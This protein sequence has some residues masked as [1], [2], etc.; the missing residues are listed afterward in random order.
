MREA[1]RGLSPTQRAGLDADLL[2]LGD[3]DSGT[4]AVWKAAK[5]ATPKIIAALSPLVRDEP[6]AAF[7]I[8]P[9]AKRGRK[10]EAEPEPTKPRAPAKSEA[11]TG[12]TGREIAELELAIQQRAA[13]DDAYFGWLRSAASLPPAEWRKRR[14][15][16]ERARGAVD[17]YVER[18][19]RARSSKARKDP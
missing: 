1:A 19:F 18:L 6:E 2:A 12:L 14:S 11:E 15:E 17:A 16:A 4:E 7:L 5:R 3:I 10:G 13:A 8:A 9:I